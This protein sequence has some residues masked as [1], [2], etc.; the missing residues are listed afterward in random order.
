MTQLLVPAV[1][2]PYGKLKLTAT[3]HP[4]WVENMLQNIGPTWRDV[5]N[6]PCFTRPLAG[7]GVEEVW[8]ILLKDFLCVIEAFPKYMG[9]MLS[10]SD[11]TLPAHR[12]AR[13]WL[14]GNIRVEANHVRWYL[15]W[16][17]AH[18]ISEEE[19]AHHVPGPESAALY[20][21]LWSVALNG[22][23]AEA[24]GA[25]NY[26]IEGVT[27]EWCRLVVGLVDSVYNKRAGMWITAHGKYDDNHPIEAL[28]LVKQLVVSEKQAER[29]QIAVS[30]SVEYYSRAIY[31]FYR[32]EA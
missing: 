24:V 29:V 14:I 2:Q 21:Y 31:S 12:K 28:E 6:A 30:R 19:L 25:V 3:P 1:Q 22:S 26:A 9:L 17:A 15:D 8:K 23:L 4:D 5:V 7:G 18:G 27:G 13:E 10:H 32:E 16:A 20:H 11:Y